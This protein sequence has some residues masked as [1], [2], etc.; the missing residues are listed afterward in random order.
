MNS[1]IIISNNILKYFYTQKLIQKHNCVLKNKL[2]KQLKKKLNY[3][4]FA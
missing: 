2:L 3:K 1:F 4:N